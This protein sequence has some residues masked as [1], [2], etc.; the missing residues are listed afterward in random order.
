MKEKIDMGKSEIKK[1]T[2]FK[3]VPNPDILDA[4]ILVEKPFDASFDVGKENKSKIRRGAYKL[5]KCRGTG[6]YKQFITCSVE[7]L[8]GSWIGTFRAF[9]RG[10]QKIK[11][12]LE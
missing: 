10:K 4:D 1:I 6:E 9:P 3:N 5:T 7:D 2:N 12:K 11:V 8:K